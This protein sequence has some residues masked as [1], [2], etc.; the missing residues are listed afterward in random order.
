MLCAGFG[1]HL[2]KGGARLKLENAWGA[3][4]RCAL[5]GRCCQRIACSVACADFLTERAAVSSAQ[6][7][8]RFGSS[9]WK[10]GMEAG[11][12]DE[13]LLHELLMSC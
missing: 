13:V 7:E 9:R 2:N 1:E 12:R 10:Q 5:L 3:W 11:K 4:R 8:A 6:R